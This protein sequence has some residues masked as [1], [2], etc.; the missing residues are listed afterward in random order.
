MAKDSKPTSPWKDAGQALDDNKSLREKLRTQ[1][2]RVKFYETLDAVRPHDIPEYTPTGGEAVAV[3]ILSDTHIEE[4]VD[5]DDVPGAVNEY[6]PDIAAKRMEQYFQRLLMLVNT[7]RHMTKI[8]TLVQGILGDIITGNIHEDL[9]ESNYMSPPKAT[10]LAE[11]F[12][13]GGLEFL[14][15]KGN[16]DKIIIPCTHG[17]HGRTTK[18]MRVKTSADNSYEWMMYQHLAKQWKHEKRLEWHIGTGL[19]VYLNLN[20][21]VCRF[22]HGDAINYQGGVGGLAVPLGKAVKDWNTVCRADLDFIGHWHQCRDYGHTIVN[23]SM[24]GYNAYALRIKAP[25]EAPKQ[26]FTLI[27]RKRGKSLFASIFTDYLPET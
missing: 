25:F 12:I 3:G 22:H 23:G 6:N 5:R 4:R 16:F 9:S 27:D 8:N 17:N 1:E 18:K 24:I 19:H 14:L 21:T 2:S 15:S 20:G 26:A 10:L 13:S 11:E 7:Q